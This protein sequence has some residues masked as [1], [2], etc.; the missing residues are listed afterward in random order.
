MV[1]S[2]KDVLGWGGGHKTIS[3]FDTEMINVESQ[4]EIMEALSEL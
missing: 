4:M 1:L 2:K 3:S